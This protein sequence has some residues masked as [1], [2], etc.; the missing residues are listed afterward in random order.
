MSTLLIKAEKAAMRYH[1][2]QS[3]LDGFLSVAEVSE[4]LELSRRHVWRLLKR[5]QA[6]GMEGLADRRIG[7]PSNNRIPLKIRSTIVE[8]MKGAL[9][10][11]PP[12]HAS[13]ILREEYDIVISRETLRKI[14]IAEGL[15]VPRSKANRNRKIPQL[16]K[17]YSNL[18]DLIQFDGTSFKWLP[19]QDP[20]CLLVF[21]DD[22]TSRLMHLALVRK[23]T[24][25]NYHREWMAYI[26][27]HGCPRRVLGDRHAAIFKISKSSGQTPRGLRTDLARALG[28]LGIHC[29][30]STT[31]TGRGR[32]ERVHRTMK[33]RLARELLRL[34]VTTI[35]GANAFFPEFIA[36]HNNHP[37]L[38]KKPECPVD[39]HFPPSPEIPI[40]LVFTTRI[41]RKVSSRL[42]VS[43]EGETLLL[44][45]IPKARVLANRKVTVAISPMGKTTVITEDGNFELRRPA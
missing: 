7:R 18:G 40:E 5:V 27:M 28:S 2:L 13:E 33:E 15:W 34:R 23:E 11:Y 14:M 16:R 39:H 38:A 3:V 36:R 6:D 19:D 32:V 29:W 4:A 8:I 35:E 26:E 37:K 1:L 24:S 21:I 45:D 41:I 31:A 10:G 42:S 9:K 44:P 25:L 20:L 17:R 43:I 22:A 30:P 12:T